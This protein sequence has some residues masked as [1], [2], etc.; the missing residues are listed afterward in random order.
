MRTSSGRDG[1]VAPDAQSTSSRHQSVIAVADAKLPRGFTVSIVARTLRR[2][3]WT[4]APTSRACS[5]SLDMRTCRRQPATIAAESA[6]DARR[7][8]CFTCRT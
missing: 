1:H 2:I 7:Q 5:S 8:S 4:P 3:S 6:Y